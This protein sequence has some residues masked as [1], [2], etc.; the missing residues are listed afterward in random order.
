MRR[1]K[2]LVLAVLVLFGLLAT[3]VMAQTAQ[4]PQIPKEAIEKDAGWHANDLTNMGVI[5][6]Q[7]HYLGMVKDMI[8]DKDGQVDYLLLSTQDGKLTPVPWSA[9][10]V[11]M[12]KDRLVVG[13]NKDKIK[14]APSFSANDMPKFDRDYEQKVLSYYGQ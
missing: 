6:R 10:D 8:V 13:F 4:Q 11:E 2:Y 3:Q 14:D 1:I 12:W 9:A 7:G 5:D